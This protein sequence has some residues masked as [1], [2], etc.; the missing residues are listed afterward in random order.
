MLCTPQV[1]GAMRKLIEPVA[2]QIAVLSLAEVT[3]DVS[4]DVVGVVGEES[5]VLQG[6]AGEEI[7]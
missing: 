3:A 6:E 5:S 4:P 2:P 7:D 1:R